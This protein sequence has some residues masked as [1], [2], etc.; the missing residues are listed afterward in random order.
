MEH[1]QEE[2]GS[3]WL[4]FWRLIELGIRDPDELDRL[5]AEMSESALVDFYWTYEEAAADLKTEEF[6]KY[7]I[8]PRTEDFVD[9]VALW[10]VAKGLAY[11]E[12]IMTNPSA[13]PPDLPPGAR[14]SPWTGTVAR[15]YRSRYRAPVRFPDDPPPLEGSDGTGSEAS[16][17]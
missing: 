2:G 3:Q 7:L 6:T 16:Q 10:I 15:V 5:I 14:L 9:D 8:P 13:M 4:G 17:T 1:Q 12:S 11:Y